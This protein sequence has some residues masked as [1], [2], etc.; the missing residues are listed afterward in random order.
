M[1]RMMR[2]AMLV[3]TGIALVSTN[4]MAQV[5]PRHAG[6]TWT[7]GVG[8]GKLK[9]ECTGCSRDARETAMSAA[10]RVGWTLHD[11]IIVSV[12]GLIFQ[13]QQQDNRG[14]AANTNYSS[15]AGV[16]QIYPSSRVGFF[17]KGGVG[18]ANI[19]QSQDTS[20]GLRDL[21]ASSIVMRLGAGTDM[22]FG[23]A[24]SLTPFI[25]YLFGSATESN[26]AGIDVK[27]SLLFFGVGITFH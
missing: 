5:G 14:E 1:I 26:V 25:D 18:I 7:G 13:K 24:W 21:E 19:S 27:P 17:F 15:D 9:T 8:L 20:L 6:L 22:R 12:D 2:L 11:Q 23:R 10:L 16:V 4:A 3:L